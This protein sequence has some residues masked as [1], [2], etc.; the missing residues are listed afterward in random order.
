MQTWLYIIFFFLFYFKTQ[1]K[2][3]PAI[4]ALLKGK[5]NSGKEK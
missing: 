4:E 2:S 1:T 3:R 5:F